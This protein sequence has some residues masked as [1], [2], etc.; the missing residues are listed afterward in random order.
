MEQLQHVDVQEGESIS[1]VT[2]LPLN[3]ALSAFEAPLQIL[4]QLVQTDESYT[5]ISTAASNALEMYNDFGQTAATHSRD[6]Q[7]IA[8]DATKILSDINQQL[9]VSIIFISLVNA[10]D[11]YKYVSKQQN[12]AAL[13]APL[14][15]LRLYED[16]R[17]YV[18]GISDPRFARFVT[19]RFY[20][21]HVT[22]QIACKIF[23][24]DALPKRSEKQNGAPDNLV[25][26]PTS[27]GESHGEDGA[28]LSPAKRSRKKKGTSEDSSS[29][30]TG[31]SADRA[32]TAAQG[33][34]DS[35]SRRVRFLGRCRGCGEQTAY[36]CL[37][38]S[39]PDRFSFFCTVR[40]CFLPHRME[41]EKDFFF[42]ESDL[43]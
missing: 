17:K 29:G 6:R 12:Q 43:E 39:S 38:C 4:A 7:S 30:T 21:Q 11:F 24:L 36:C 23:G 1:M 41:V 18:L 32:T 37:T 10:Y 9:F 35:G 34:E 28:A 16:M 13:S 40:G 8:I 22:A 33:Q 27:A 26:M 20:C 19:H 2:K 31:D 25:D 15:Y 5:F 3:G 42:R 14:F